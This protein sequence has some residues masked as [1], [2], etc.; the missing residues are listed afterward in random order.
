MCGIA[1]MIHLTGSAPV[2]THALS[3][4][5]RAIFHRGPDEEGFLEV[6]GLGLASR[7]LSI[8]GLADGRQPVGNEDGSVVVVFNQ[9][10][11]FD[12]QE[13]RT[14]LSQRGHRLR[15]YCDTEI[16]AALVGRSRRRHAR[17]AARPVRL[18][19][20]GRQET[21]AGASRRGSVRHLPPVL[22][23]PGRLAAVRLGNQRAARVLA[24]CRARSIRQLRHQPGDDLFRQSRA[25]DLLS[26]RVQVAG[27]AGTLPI[28]CN[29][30][31]KGPRQRSR[32]V[33]HLLGDRFPPPRGRSRGRPTSKKI[34]DGF[35]AVLL[36][37]ARTAGCGPMCRSCAISAAASTSEHR[38]RAGHA[39][40]E[41]GRRGRQFR[42]SRSAV[43]SK[44]LN[45]ESEAALVARHVGCETVVVK[46]GRDEVLD[47]YPALIPR[48]REVP[49]I[50]TAC[51][52]L[53]L[54]LAREVHA[55]GYKVAL[56]GE[57]A[58]EWLAG[59]PWYHANKMLGGLDAVPGLRLSSLAKQ[60][61]LRYLGAPKSAW[62]LQVRNE[63]TLGGK[64]AWLEIYG[65]HT[66]WPSCVCTGRAQM[67]G[68]PR[69]T[70][71]LT[72]TWASTWT[73]RAESGRRWNRSL[74]LGARVMLP[75]LLLASK[76][77]RVAMNSSVET[78]YPFLDEDVF[79][80]CASLRP[81]W[82]LRGLREKE[83]LRLFAQRWL[84]KSIAWR[85]KAMFR[86]PLDGFF[87]E[88]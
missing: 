88:E 85:R 14:T 18:C 5:A 9:R 65:M 56:T 33:P 38:G 32:I 31:R 27:D 59:Y 51:A 12:H 2:P 52:A 15:T 53:L 69:A 6:P 76:G 10:E 35:E 30:A 50:D 75:G 26:G 41:K 48:R 82:K 78:R 54:M 47:T 40:A 62:D 68:K 70:T 83:A 4:M 45:E 24:W 39:P 79:D 1:G 55:H 13:V 60:A 84:P 25:A 42:R 72:K 77:D 74:Y 80:F 22:D 66:V 67:W 23:A 28:R 29:W 87:G 3:A 63:K 58:D 61:Y 81:E 86:P 49:V 71:A 36:K 16:V 21:P 43:Q 7:R 64:N 57:G 37:A 20:V 46:F 44:G 17:K 8:V 73:R 34:A 19:P 11:L